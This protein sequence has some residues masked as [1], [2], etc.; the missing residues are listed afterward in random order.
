MKFGCVFPAVEIGDDSAVVRDFA[1][2]RRRDRS[3]RAKIV[4]EGR[5][6]TAHSGQAT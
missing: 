6:P 5:R 4:L 2:R 1:H 3:C